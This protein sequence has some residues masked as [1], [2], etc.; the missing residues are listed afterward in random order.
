MKHI[1]YILG[2]FPTL[3]E[4]FIINEL[5]E[6]ERLGL[7]L[8]ILSTAR[9]GEIQATMHAFAQDLQAHTIYMPG[10]HR[11]LGAV[12]ARQLL[13]HPVRCLKMWRLN[14]TAP[15]L[16]GHSKTR[17]WLKC[18][19]V[20]R[21]VDQVRPDHLHGH[22]TTPSDVARIVAQSAQL[23]FSF[24]LHAHD[25]YDEDPLLRAQGGGAAARWVG[26]TFVATCTD[27]NRQHLTA[28]YGAQLKAPLHTVYHGVDTRLFTPGERQWDVPVVLSVGRIIA[29]KGFDR[30]VEILIRLHATGTVFK[31]YLVGDGS[32]REPLSAR[33]A[34]LGLTDCITLC[35]PLP[36]EAVRD[37]YAKADVF[38]LAG[39]VERGQHGLPNVL[40]EAMSAGLIVVTTNL[41]PVVELIDH[42]VNGY[43][44]PDDDAA[45]EVKLREVL[46]DPGQWATIGSNARQKVIERFSLAASTRQLYGLFTG[47]TP[48]EQ[49]LVAA[50]YQQA[51][52]R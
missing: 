23:P 47:D 10:T 34:S 19:V 25:I 51:S 30:L 21:Y 49:A 29:Y 8:S 28:T 40:V 20:A 52:A 5:N 36:A 6:I 41:P 14:R 37:Y 50:P 13:R 38:T 1:L 48:P 46:A 45:I 39:S 44:V 33:V 17:R 11:E 43:I 31:A 16:P 15:V 27:Y 2:N 12:V 9:R 35:G 18:L 3:S 22:W 26:A 32:L 24:T 4:T 42:G 7:K